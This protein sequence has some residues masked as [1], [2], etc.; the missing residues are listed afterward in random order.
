MDIGY[1]DVAELGLLVPHV[2]HIV[3]RPEAARLAQPQPLADPRDRR[4]AQPDLRLM[5][6]VLDF[7]LDQGAHPPPC[8]DT[9]PGKFLPKY[10]QK[11]A[12]TECLGRGAPGRFEKPCNIEAD[13]A[14]GAFSPLCGHRTR[15]RK[16]AG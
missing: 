15:D 16:T 1:P 3:R 5:R 8:R 12:M 7:D 6:L 11:V 9:L 14:D 2:D 4:E 10:E 13:K